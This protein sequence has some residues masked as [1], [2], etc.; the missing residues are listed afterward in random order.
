MK[1]GILVSLASLLL[2][3]CAQIDAIPL[4][5][6]TLAAD[7]NK[8]HGIRYYVPKPYLLV[9][10]LPAPAASSQD[11]K[12]TG[13]TTGG[14]TK[15][16]S[17]STSKSGTR[18]GS[19]G[20]GAA[21]SHSSGGTG[22][23]SASSSDASGKKTGDGSAPQSAPATAQASDLSFA[24]SMAQYSMKLVYLPDFDQPMALQVTSGMFG[25]TSFSPTLQDGW[26]LSTLNGSVDSGGSNVLQTVQSIAS[27]V[28][29]TAKTASTGG[30]AALTRAGTAADL[31]TATGCEQIGEEIGAGNLPFS[32]ATGTG[33]KCSSSYLSSLVAGIS[34]GSAQK[35]QQGASAWSG[36]ILP[37]GLYEINTRAGKMPF[38][39]VMFFCAS[40]PQTAPCTPAAGQSPSGPQTITYTNSVPGG[41]NAAP[42]SK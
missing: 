6:D 17:K 32:S 34:K 10:A 25:T 16:K 38:T 29:G 35:G 31:T 19:T 37:P 24:A 27:G 40:G 21:S 5:A 20:S 28:L 13:Q 26:M 15:S 33:S 4:N 30:A 9:A 8:A 1:H 12:T 7:P 22:S 39:A 36:D 11:G 14:A 3:S 42:P 23:G 18:S 2:C 41:D